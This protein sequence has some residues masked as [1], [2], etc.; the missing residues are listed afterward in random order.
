MIGH[1]ALQAYA[2]KG[3]NSFTK[4]RLKEK[5]RWLKAVDK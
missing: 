2:G 4:I 1:V 3:I 5:D